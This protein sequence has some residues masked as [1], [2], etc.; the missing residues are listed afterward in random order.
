MARSERRAASAHRDEVP[1]QPRLVLDG[2]VHVLLGALDVDLGVVDVGVLGGGVV[3]PDDDVLH[4]VGGDAASH[5][6]LR[7][8][9]VKFFGVKED[10]KR[11]SRSRFVSLRDR[12]RSS[13]GRFQIL[14]D[15][16]VCVCVRTWELARLW[17]SRVR[18]EKFSL[19]M[20]GAD[21]EA[22]RQLVFAGFP[23][24]KTW[25][26]EQNQS[27]KRQSQSIK[28]QSPSEAARGQVTGSRT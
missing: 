23:T 15:L 21:L 10:F 3:P 26:E 2:V 22:I 25:S 18:Q 17:S 5:R 6:H 28:G 27:I 20:D 16:C 12:I 13:A 14:T 1:P 19:G 7:D 24:T 11:T 4:F 9:Q 8:T